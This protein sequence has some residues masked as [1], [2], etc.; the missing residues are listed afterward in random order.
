MNYPKPDI[1]PNPAEGPVYITVPQ[2]KR[3]RRHK[4]EPSGPDNPFANFSNGGSNV[5]LWVSLGAVLVAG[6]G[7]YLAIKKHTAPAK[8]RR[9]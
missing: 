8:K 4:I 3:F 7:A 2:Y 5:A 6:L 1:L 9:K